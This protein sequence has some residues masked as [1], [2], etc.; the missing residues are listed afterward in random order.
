MADA[1]TLR[2]VDAGYGRVQVL[3]AL[4]L[5]LREGE[6]LCLL[7]RNGAGKTTALKTVMG[8]VP[9]SAGS[10]R[11]GGIELTALPAHEVP[12]AG[13]AY[14]PQGRRLFAEL[15]VAE[16][17]EIGLSARRK[18]EAVREAV[19]DLFPILRERYR[20]R[21]GT[22]S[23]GEQQML[24]MARALCLEPQVLLLDE[25]TEGL[26][27]SMIARIRDTVAV[28]RQRGVSTL[29][30]EQRV[31]AVLPVADRVAFIENGRNRETV[32]IERLRAEPELVKK[33]VGLA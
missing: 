14:V 19:L 32:G 27:P 22:L 5:E 29:L 6:V 23:G 26:M 10:I 33:Y 16:N 21:S 11:L 4:S 9:A 13:V 20:Q 2:D 28:L 7:G 3:H 24:A 12:K 31:D 1:L 15:S 18:C 25:P 8:L 17:L 30:V